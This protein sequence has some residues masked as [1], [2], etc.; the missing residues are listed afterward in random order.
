M[1]NAFIWLPI[2]GA[3]LIAYTPLEAKKVRGLALTLAVVLLLLNI[4][5]G[6][7]FDPSNPQMQFTVNLPWI[8]FLGFN[9]ALGVDGLSFSLLFLNSILTIIALYASGTEVNRPRFYY[10]LLLLLN[11][12][13]AGAFL[14][15]DL[16]LF[17]LFYELEIVPLYFLIAIWG[18]QRRGYAGMK[19]LLYTAISGFLVLISFLGLVWLTGA[20]NFAYNPLLSNNLDVKTQLLLLIPLLIGLAIK[21]PIFP[22]HTWLPDAHVEA[23]TPVSVL[24]AGIL[25]KLG[26]YGL[27][28]FGVGLFLDA[29]VTLAP[30]LAT[31]AAI[32][33]LYG[34]SCA[35]AQKDMKKVVAYSSISH[36]AYILLAAAATTRLS[37]TAAILQMISHGLI[38]ALL[39]LLVGV[40]YKKTGSRDVNYLRGLLNPERGLPIT[41][42]LMI[43]AA[44][45]SAGIPGMVG[46]IAEFLV[47]RGSF[48]IFPIQTLLCLVASGLTAVYFLLM[49]N[50]VFFGRL[51]P[52]L[53][54]IPRSTWPERFPEIAL[55][56]FII[57]LGLQPSW[58]IHWSENQAS[59]LLTGTAISQKQS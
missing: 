40:V 36:M 14:A 46:F 41:G 50:R 19:F 3:I 17:F 55:A 8:N 31:I 6:W 52:E 21:I 32:S 24:L 26:T 53:S 57:V 10:S 7:Q 49:I 12:G 28:R 43:L 20:N 58:M 4:L 27:L 11:A 45:A 15:Q 47:F 44:M 37:I 34:A 18:G 42:M 2:I 35:I 25:L 56:L 33:A 16:L 9:Y 23:S 48:P 39:F 30:W 59:M 29:W 51:T 22:F 5:L 38:S 13:V 54:R 1:L